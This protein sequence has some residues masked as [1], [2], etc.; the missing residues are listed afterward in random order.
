MLEPMQL[1]GID[2]VALTCRSVEATMKWYVD[3]LGFEHVFPGAWD[4]V[5]V[6]LKLGTTHLALF[7]MNG[8]PQT[9][10]QSPG[11]D[12]LAFNAATRADFMLARDSLTSL[13]MA[14][15]FVDH[16]LSHSIYFTDP[17]GR[18]LEITTYDVPEA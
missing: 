12:H 4:G 5:P 18:K 7:P 14:S 1:A 11:F 8:D 6:F 16:E 10:S 17:D 2:H 13:G 15:D 9:A 3:V